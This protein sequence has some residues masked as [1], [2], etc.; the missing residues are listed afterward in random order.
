MPDTSEPADSAAVV[1]PREIVNDDVVKIVGW[2]VQPGDR[3]RKGELLLEV[4]TS[5]ATIAIEAEQDG[6]LEIL[7]PKGADAAIGQKVAYLHPEPVKATSVPQ[8]AADSTSGSPAKGQRISRK[9]RELIKENGLDVSVFSDLSLVREAD[10][11]RYL[12][13]QKAVNRSL[14]VDGRDDTAKPELKA[15]GEKPPAPTSPV[16]RGHFYDARKSASDRGRS[17]LGLACDYFFRN[18]LLGLLVRVAPRPVNL[19]L[20]RLRGV[21]MGQE[22]FID[23]TAVVETA[24]PENVTLGNDVRIAAH[25]V[26]MT[27]IK[28]PHHLRDTDLLPTVMNKV[29]LEDHCFIGVNAVVMPGV[30]VG[31]ASVVAS[32]AVVVTNVPPYTMV[33]GN[34]AKVVKRFSLPGPAES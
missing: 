28:P 9:A 20:H 15:A 11:L 12:D 25:A 21:K 3:V 17:V 16:K 33:S 19:L 22:C 2:H 6:Y 8:L 13:G 30:T 18:Y 1:V 5:K 34:P 26:I 32:G 23:P 29:V 31:L 7:K 24:Y 10:V 27:H 14:A 4:E